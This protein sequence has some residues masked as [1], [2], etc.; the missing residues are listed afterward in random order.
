[1]SHDNTEVQE[2]NST[3]MESL[4]ENVSMTDQ[5]VNKK[6]EEVTENTIIPDMK[7]GVLIEAFGFMF[8]ILCGCPVWISIITGHLFDKN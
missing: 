7:T 8:L 3:K 2:F 5:Q 4:Q 1:M 6:T